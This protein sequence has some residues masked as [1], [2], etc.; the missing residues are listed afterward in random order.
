MGWEMRHGQSSTCN[1]IFFDKLG[2]GDDFSSLQKRVK[3]IAF[4]GSMIEVYL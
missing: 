1:S 4:L 2:R 3:D